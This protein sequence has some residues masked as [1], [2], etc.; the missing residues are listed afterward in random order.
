MDSTKNSAMPVTDKGTSRC[1]IVIRCAYLAKVLFTVLFIFQMAGLKIFAFPFSIIAPL[2]M[3]AYVFGS[4]KFIPVLS[5]GIFV[6]GIIVLIAWF[7]ALP[8]LMFWRSKVVFSVGNIIFAVLNLFDATCVV[9]SESPARAL[10]VAVNVA[11]I[12]VSMLWFFKTS[13]KRTSI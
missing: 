10:Y 3:F 6:L 1:K 5:L 13:K 9:F 12:A 4:T 11:L 2:Y 8:F 7:L